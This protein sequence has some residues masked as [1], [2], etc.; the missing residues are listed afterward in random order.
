[1]ATGD[2]AMDALNNVNSPSENDE[3]TEFVAGLGMRPINKPKRYG[4]HSTG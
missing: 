2:G 4:A 3:S 1:M